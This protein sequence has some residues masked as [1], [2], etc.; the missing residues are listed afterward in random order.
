MA[1][2]KRQ[3]SSASAAGESV[4]I[5]GHQ[6]PGQFFLSLEWKQHYQEPYVELCEKHSSSIVTQLFGHHSKEMMRSWSENAGALVN[7]G[8][9]PS[10]G[11]G[12]GLSPVGKGR[13]PVN[14]S[15][16]VLTIEKG[17]L[18]A[19]E[20]YFADLASL[21]SSNDVLGK[22]WASL[23]A[24]VGPGGTTVA[25]LAHIWSPMYSF[26]ETYLVPD[27]S[28]KSIAM[29]Q[30]KIVS[31]SRWGALYSLIQ[32]AFFRSEDPI[33]CDSGQYTRDGEASCMARRCRFSVT[34]EC[35]H[36]EDEADD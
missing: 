3:L 25:R 1:W 15:F 11:H 13:Q 9:T 4:V 24:D 7:A 22:G 18:A 17:V 33:V 20:S 36:Y 6:P 5:L 8:M 27:V 31:H 23:V 35:A 34:R 26:T 12:K 28:A 32:T 29:A 30:Q 21:G 10:G 14:P 16:G 2:L 19:Y